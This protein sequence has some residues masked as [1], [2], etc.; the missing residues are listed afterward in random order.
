MVILTA[1]PQLE[2]RSRKESLEQEAAGRTE[3]VESLVSPL[4]ST[5]RERER[6]PQCCTGQA[7]ITYQ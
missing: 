5:E 6:E 7:C 3:W 4:P 2:R 1:V